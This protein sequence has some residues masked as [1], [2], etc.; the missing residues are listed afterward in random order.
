L[1]MLDS[2]TKNKLPMQDPAF[3]SGLQK[4]LD[5]SDYAKRVIERE[6]DWITQSW[7]KNQFKTG[8]ATHQQAL[9]E[10]VKRCGSEQ[11][12]MQLIRH[13]RHQSLFSLMWRDIVD[14]AALDEIMNGL[15]S[16]ASTC[17]QAAVDY[18]YQHLSVFGQPQAELVV[19][20]MGK[21]GG[22]E[23]NFSSDI[24]LIF[25]YTEK[26]ETDGQRKISHEQFYTRLVKHVSHWLS[27]PTQDGFAYRVDL[28]LRP[29]GDGG[30]LALSFAAMEH[31]YQNDGREWERYALIKARPVAGQKKAGK[32]LLR[33]LQA[34]IYRRYLDYGAFENL[35]EMKVMIQQEVTRKGLVDDIKLGSGGIR[36]IEF[37]AQAFQLVRG[38]RDH[39]LREVSLLPTLRQLAKLN[40][41]NSPTVSKL[42][43]AYQFLRVLENRIQQINDEQQ[44]Q[45]PLDFSLQGRLTR[46]MG[47]T[48]WSTLM[49]QLNAHRYQVS[50]CFKALFHQPEQQ[51]PAKEPAQQLW[52]SIW[53]A[54]PNVMLQLLAEHNFPQGEFIVEQLQRLKQHANL[55]L[56]GPKGQKR[57][58]R[59]MPNVLQQI[60]AINQV[61]QTLPRISE[62]IAN[63][64]RR[65]AYLALLA[66]HPM[67]LKRL[68]D[69]LSQ[70]AWISEQINRHPLLLDD[71]IDPRSSKGQLNTCRLTSE[72]ERRTNLIEDEETRMD[73]LRQLQ[74]SWWL[75]VTQQHLEQQQH[76][77]ITARSL[78]RIAEVLLTQVF[79]DAWAD[80]IKRY[81]EPSGDHPAMAV[82]AYGTLGGREMNFGSDLD[83]VFL[84]D[85]SDPNGQ[86]HGPKS[87][88]NEVFFNRLIRKILHGITT[89]T[90][91]GR[92]YAVDNRLRPNGSSGLLVSS[93]GAF[94]RYQREKA[95]TWELQA[96][97][98]SR[99]VA[100]HAHL[101]PKFSAL[102]SELLSLPRS[103]SGLWTDIC[104]MRGRMRQELGQTHHDLF[105]LK[106]GLGGIVDLEFISQ[107]ARLYWGQ[108]DPRLRAL[109]GTRTSLSR[110]KKHLPQQTA[111]LTE[112]ITSYDH[113]QTLKQ[114]LALN[115]QADH[116]QAQ[117]IQH[118]TDTVNKLWQY[119]S[120]DSTDN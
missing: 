98:R 73:L 85:G 86:T 18:A 116:I 43:D 46:S 71:L 26:G 37:I 14:H 77:T 40:M 49:D 45:L 83:L 6:S 112:A 42:I 117:Q 28:R 70:S 52:T 82:I 78:S 51:R 63:I 30:R 59:L 32:A 84:Y 101:R 80:S 7:S 12:L 109:T 27:T 96:L 8:S 34:F 67:V 44:H 3:R 53:H 75:T 92:L 55:K 115:Q 16:T 60:T 102:R 91:S 13:F 2:E 5:L 89:Q 38:G 33:L 106:H 23:L 20:G 39:T 29:F 105:D 76:Q 68:I 61:S 11:H 113:Y 74:N 97:S 24:D 120:S 110:L 104:E 100:G 69:L 111:L 64:A 9:I 95:W 94:E 66:D 21:L 57:L 119:I 87:L 79:T 56:L 15:S 93:F 41:L 107:Y 62:F 10:S 19:L 118:D 88:D 114:H 90:T 81:G 108:H 22:N 4:I 31:Y 48:D 50:L 17:I 35:S 25:A 99:F 36:E 47:F 103:K 72:L 58:H 65:S 1:N 54:E